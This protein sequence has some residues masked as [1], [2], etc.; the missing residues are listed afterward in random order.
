[1]RGAVL[2]YTRLG[3]RPFSKESHD[4]RPTE[5]TYY[6]VYDLAVGRLRHFLA[7]QKLVCEQ[8]HDEQSD[9]NLAIIFYRE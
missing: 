5:H 3:S 7:K 1:M 8:L 4:R 2:Q 6:C 9:I